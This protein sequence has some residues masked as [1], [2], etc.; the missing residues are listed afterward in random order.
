MW[1]R[2][3]WS[4]QTQLGFGASATGSLWSSTSGAY[5]SWISGAHGV[6]F[7]FIWFFSLDGLVIVWWLRS[8]RS[9]LSTQ[10][11]L[12]S[13]AGDQLNGHAQYDGVFSRK[14][15]AFGFSLALSLNY[16][17]FRVVALSVGDFHICY[18]CFRYWRGGWSDVKGF[19]ISERRVRLQKDL[20]RYCEVVSGGCALRS[21]P[22]MHA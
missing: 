16:L 8:P 11:I 19:F 17:W 21:L 15:V 10:D 7:G 14:G 1:L 22:P 6:A 3:P 9:D 4:S 2:S 20:A 5:S 12:V 18:L 13:T